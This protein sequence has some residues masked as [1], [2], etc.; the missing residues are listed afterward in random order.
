[1]S[2]QHSVK[3]STP[4]YDITYQF[5]SDG[6]NIQ[7]KTIQKV[8]K[9]AETSG[10]DLTVV[11]TGLELESGTINGIAVVE[12]A[13][14]V[15]PATVFKSAM[16]VDRTEFCGNSGGNESD[17]ST[18][19]LPADPDPVQDIS[20]IETNTVVSESL[21]ALSEVPGRG[22]MFYSNLTRCQPFERDLWYVP[23]SGTSVDKLEVTFTDLVKFYGTHLELLEEQPALKIAVYH[24]PSDSK[25]QFSL[26]ASLADQQEATELATEVEGAS[27]MNFYRFE[28]SKLS[29]VVGQTT[30][31]PDSPGAVFRNGDGSRSPVETWRISTG[32]RISRQ[33]II[34]WG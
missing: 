28:L 12:L 22:A 19:E 8:E 20:Q 13:E 9:E 15:D 27:A 1:V 18:T 24:R 5:E 14:N 6:G 4:L 34:H 2:P 23:I 26:V 10:V 33:A 16:N 32:T 21:T 30:H 11:T 31:G 29:L 25:I 7:Y 17:E 3:S